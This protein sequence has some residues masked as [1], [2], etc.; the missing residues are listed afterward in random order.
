MPK[1]LYPTDF[2]EL[3]ESALLPA[4][5][6]A[7]DRGAKLLIAHIEE[8][9]HYP[10]GET[11]RGIANPDSEQLKILMH[12]LVPDDAGVECEYHL[13]AGEAAEQICKLAALQNVE[14]IVMS[15]HGRTGLKRLLTGSVTE[16][17]MRHAPCPVFVY[18]HESE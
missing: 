12:D 9:E 8:S 7:R 4:L 5:A 2:S 6:L 13:I 10:H 18:R 14:L 17:V 11:V 1:I 15:T 16:E 3:S